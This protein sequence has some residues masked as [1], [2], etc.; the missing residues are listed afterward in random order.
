[1]PIKFYSVVV[2][3]EESKDLTQLSVDELMGSLLAHEQR[4]NRSG[5]SSLENAFKAQLPFG[6]TRGRSNYSR[7]SRHFT[8]RGGRE[9]TQ[10]ERKHTCKNRHTCRNKTLN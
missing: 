5:A 6:K 10:L 8:P 1:M 2:A 3:I 7:G 4:L 9:N